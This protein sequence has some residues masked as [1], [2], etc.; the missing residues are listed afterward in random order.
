MKDKTLIIIFGIILLI[1]AANLGKLPTFILYGGQEIE[2]EISEQEAQCW[3]LGASDSCVKQTIF[4]INFT[5]Q[6]L[7]ACPDS[8]FPTKFECEKHYGLIKEEKPKINCYF[9]SEDDC[10]MEL[11]ELTSC[12]TQYYSTI[13]E[14]TE[15]LETPTLHLKKLFTNPTTLILLGIVI[16]ILLFFG[17]RKFR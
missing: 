2:G 11:F 10:Q 15:A 7:L 14:C 13:G 1:L 6:N 5:K 4:L 9:I 12:P 3:I 17:I 8:Y 16:A